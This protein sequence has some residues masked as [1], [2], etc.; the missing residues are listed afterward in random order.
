VNI[1][2][3]NIFNADGPVFW[4]AFSVFNLLSDLACLGL[5]MPVL[6]KLKLPK[7]QK[8]SLIF[9]FALGTL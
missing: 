3:A 9:V 1:L 7:K 8:V 5:P 2:D 4:Y 6:V